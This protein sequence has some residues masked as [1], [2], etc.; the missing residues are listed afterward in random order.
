VT[1]VDWRGGKNSRRATVRYQYSVHGRAFT[2]SATMRQLER[3]AYQVGSPIGVWYL[4]SQPDA[5]WIDG[6]WPQPESRWPV[7]AVFAPC[8][9]AALGLMFVVRR[10]SHLLAYGRPALATVRRVEQ[11]KS[12]EGR[13]W[14][15]HFEW[16]LLSG[17]TRS[18]RYH[19]HRKQPPAVGAVIPIVYDRDHPRRY[20]RYPLALVRL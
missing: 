1:D 4:A 2:G 14:R 11:K 17:A 12:D 15:V 16:T 9:L 3:D 19:H 5:S 13:Y 8:G 6:D 10:Q 7:F 18:G 20:S